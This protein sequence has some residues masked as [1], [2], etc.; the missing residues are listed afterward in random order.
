MNKTASWRQRLGCSLPRGQ[1]QQSCDSTLSRQRHLA[2]S[3]TSDYTAQASHRTPTVLSGDTSPGNALTASA[4]GLTVF[5][6]MALG[7]APGE[8]A[9]IV[10]DVYFNLC[11]FQRVQLRNIRFMGCEFAGV[12]FDEVQFGPG[13][14]FE[15]CHFNRN[16]DQQGDD[17][18]GDGAAL[19]QNCQFFGN[20]HRRSLRFITCDLRWAV[21]LGCHIESITI[22]QSLLSYATFAE[23]HLLSLEFKG[24][25]LSGG[26]IYR[27]R[28]LDLYFSDMEHTLIDGAFFLDH[29]QSGPSQITT[30][31]KSIRRLVRLLEYHNLDHLA[32]EYI[33]RAKI[34]EEQGLTGYPRLIS[35][36]LRWLC[37]YGER[38]SYTLAIILLHNIPFGFL[39]LYNGISTPYGVVDYALNGVNLAIDGP[40]I[41]YLKCLFFSLST[42]TTV[43]YGNFLPIN[44]M[45][46]LIT[47]IQMILGLLLC[48][49]WTGCVLRKI[50]R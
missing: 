25:D 8:A 46:M 21:F 44:Q 47:G 14:S 29:S 26:A 41:D 32:G 15:N 7:S 20:Y 39:Y 22:H 37:G 2:E 11:Q 33:Y 5:R 28:A 50:S 36:C 3:H 43:G 1:Y 12:V 23:S 4:Y 27:P 10:S 13:V 35:Y 42:F 16:G 40:W 45:G 24:C 6:D 48:A 19:F 17:L 38:P 49:L 30:H 31:V 9:Q 18:S 34:L